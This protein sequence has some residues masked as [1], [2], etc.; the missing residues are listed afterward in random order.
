MGKVPDY[1]KKAIEKYHSKFD[2]FTVSLPAGMREK[3]T[4][5]TGLSANAYINS[6]VAADLARLEAAAAGGPEDPEE[7]LPDWVIEYTK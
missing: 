6:L 7:G 4:A 5:L 2:R 1:T 3:I